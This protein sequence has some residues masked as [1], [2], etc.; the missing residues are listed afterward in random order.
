MEPG[1]REIR[2]KMRNVLIAVTVLLL[3]VCGFTQASMNVPTA[4]SLP[5]APAPQQIPGQTA[6]GMAPNGPA[7]A[8]PQANSTAPMTLSLKQA[9][10]L[11]IKNNP[12]I[13][14]A[15]LMALA[16]EQVTR[17]VRSNL[18][19][20]ATANL[21]GVDSREDSRI[22]AGGLN[23]PIIYERAAAGVM[24]NQLITDFGRTTNL[25]ASASY[26]AKAE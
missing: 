13:S 3:P 1:V 2:V 8:N 26:A 15:R 5:A 4:Q 9:E 22:T 16:S 24:V 11:A 17:E 6:P 12:Q 7:P 25:A 21:T 18:W 23:N 19:P 20:T 14:V 10:A